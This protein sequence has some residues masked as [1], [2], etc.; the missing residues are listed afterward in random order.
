MGLF[1][2]FKKKTVNNGA[3]QPVKQEN[4]GQQK[5]AVSLT[6]NP[7]LN[8]KI[9]LR[10]ELVL[11]EVKK[12]NISAQVA[13]VVFVLDH[14]GSM[15]TMYKNGTVQEVL[16][17][18]FPIAMHFDDNAEMEFYWFDNKF[19]ELDAVNY[20]N[21]DGYVKDVILSRGDNFGTTNYAPVME[22]ILNR[23]GK[24]DIAPIPT[25]VIFITDGNNADKK[26]AKDVLTEASRFNIF[27]KFVGIGNEKYDFLAKLDDLEGRF[28]DN[29]NFICVDNLAKLSD[30]ELYA[31]LLTEYGDWLGLCRQNGIRVDG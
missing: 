3:A 24:K 21:L 26:A 6:K 28:I 5:A 14:S 16:E 20:S 30:K 8:K 9:S 2:A 17:R 11:N 25:F 4:F 19:K 23:Y 7:E 10:K 22:S 12:Q 15:R 29:A 1:D 31:M 27:W 18:I 13:R